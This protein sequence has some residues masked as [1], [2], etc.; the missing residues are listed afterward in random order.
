MNDR[1]RDLFLYQWSRRRAPG[2]GRIALRGAVIG[3]LGGLAFAAIMLG[4]GARLPGVHAYDTG[5]Q[6]ES[7]LGLL[8]MAVPTFA[9]LGWQNAR[10]IWRSHEGMYQRLLASGAR[11]PDQKPT[12]GLGDRGPQ[13]AVGITVLVIGGFI[14]YLFWAASTG[15]L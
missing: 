6:L 1:Q 7:A 11:V 8:A 3:G 14:A 12:L 10:R 5:G 13:I 2:G 4:G 15:N 9:L